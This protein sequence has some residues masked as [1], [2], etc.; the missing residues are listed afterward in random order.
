MPDIAGTGFEGREDIIRQHV[1]PGMPVYL[2]RERNNPHDPNAVAVCIK[3][4]FLFIPQTLKIGY[5]DRTRAAKLVTSKMKDTD[6]IEGHVV[7]CFTDMKHPRV[8]ASW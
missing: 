8:T 5:V 4:S 7:S 6:Q 1:K 3:T 2:I